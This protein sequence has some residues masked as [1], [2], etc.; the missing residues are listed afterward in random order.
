MN[1]LISFIVIFITC[2]VMVIG[3]GK[4]DEPVQSNQKNNDFENNEVT[5]NTSEANHDEDSN[6]SNDNHVKSNYKGNYHRSDEEL[7]DLGEIKEEID[8]MLDL[9]EV[10]ENT[11][12]YSG[13]LNP[14]FPWEMKL[15]DEEESIEVKVDDDGNFSVDISEAKL[16]PG[17]EVIFYVSG[18]EEFECMSRSVEVQSD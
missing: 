4:N 5:S 12:E 14:D 2:S 7:M 3:C 6:N 9:P 11:E 1:K 10:N 17:D 15:P 16:E 8:K 18:G 13:T